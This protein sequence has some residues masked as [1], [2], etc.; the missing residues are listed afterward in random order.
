MLKAKLIQAFRDDFAHLDKLISQGKDP[1]AIERHALCVEGYLR[2]LSDPDDLDD[3]GGI[4]SE[5]R[6]VAADLRQVLG[7]P[8]TQRKANDPNT[9]WYMHYVDG[10][11]WVP[12]L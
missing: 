12:K 11:G 3:I 6:Q 7:L 1:A 8:A 4:V 5:A 9:A 10:L 2:K